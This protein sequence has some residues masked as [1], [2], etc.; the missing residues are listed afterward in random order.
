MSSATDDDD[1]P[2]DPTP[3]HACY[4]KKC[5]P[6]HI[7]HWLK[8]IVESFP[9]ESPTTMSKRPL[10]DT[11][12]EDE[13]DS[14]SRSQSQVSSLA[15]TSQ[16]AR[17]KKKSKGEEENEMASIESFN[18]RYKVHLRTDAEVLGK[19]IIFLII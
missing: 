6:N 19:Q 10:E 12:S 3:F 14:R 2:S 11:D 13:D 8:N 16:S 17:K 7:P 1:G 18:K 15:K 5:S 9:L 4:F